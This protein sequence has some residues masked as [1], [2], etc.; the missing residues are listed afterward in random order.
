[1]L[2]TK[3]LQL[4]LPPL[5]PLL[6]LPLL[7]LLS[8]DQWIMLTVT[9]S[10]VDVDSNDDNGLLDDSYHAGDILTTHW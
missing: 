2:R 3:P 7:M 9:S 10:D 6:P 1:M 8:Y 4:L 5:L